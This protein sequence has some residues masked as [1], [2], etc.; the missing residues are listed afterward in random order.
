MGTASFVKCR[1]CGKIART[2][3]KICP[4]CHPARTA[5]KRP[6]NAAVIAAGIAFAGIAAGMAAWLSFGANDVVRPEEAGAAPAAVNSSG[7]GDRHRVAMTTAIARSVKNSLPDPDAL[8]WERMLVNDSA[9]VIC[10]EYKV[11]TAPDEYR[12][13]RFSYVDGKTSEQVEDWH[14]HCA[15]KRF[16]DMA[17]LKET[18]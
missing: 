3:V 16:N 6:P 14:R 17:H 11:K 7:D 18:I 2:E 12:E 10:L 1:K 5:V 13:A 9:S 15:D 4:A 8:V